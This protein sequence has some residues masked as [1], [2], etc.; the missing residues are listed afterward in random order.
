MKRHCHFGRF[1]GQGINN[2]LK[3]R[4]LSNDKQKVVVKSFRR[5]ETSHM[6]LYAKPTIEKNPGKYYHSLI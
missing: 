3:G 4:Q 2:D 1:N 6:P 5:A